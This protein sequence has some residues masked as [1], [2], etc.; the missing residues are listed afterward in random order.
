MLFP[1]NSKKKKNG[2][3]VRMQIHNLKRTRCVIK[4]NFYARALWRKQFEYVLIIIIQK[5]EQQRRVITCKKTTHGHHND[6]DRHNN[7]EMTM[8]LL[9]LLKQEYKQ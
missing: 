8:T 1:I 5:K 3:E 9:L 2:I 4:C 6:Y 7:D